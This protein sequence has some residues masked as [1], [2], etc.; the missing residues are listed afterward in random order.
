[1]AQQRIPQHAAEPGQHLQVL[2]DVG[3]DQKEE[4]PGGKTV[5]GPKR[6]AGLVPAEDNRRLLDQADKGIARMREGHP[7]AHAGAAK[8]F[9]FLQGAEQRLFRPG[10]ARQLRDFIH[11]FLEHFVPVAAAQA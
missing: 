8:Q 1:M 7:V 9:A 10:I 3:G 2:A 11:E 6:D 5:E 4:E